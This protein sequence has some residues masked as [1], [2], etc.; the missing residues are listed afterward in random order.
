MRNIY[1]R[2]YI[3]ANRTC[4]ASMKGQHVFKA[5]I[6]YERFGNDI[7]NARPSRRSTSTGARPTTHR[8]PAVHGTYGYYMLNKTGTVG[9]VNSNNY[10]FW[11]QDSWSVNSRLTIN[12]GVRLENEMVPSYKTTADAID[13]QFGFSE[14]VAPR[15]GFA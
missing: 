8:G 15:L 3:N 6:R 13:I 7:Y 2:L 5:G 10:R 11:L 9:D 12:A 1:D 4:F 14:K